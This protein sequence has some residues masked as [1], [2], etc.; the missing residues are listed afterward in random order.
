M[1]LNQFFK[2]QNISIPSNQEQQIQNYQ[3]IQRQQ[4]QQSQVVQQQTPVDQQ[5]HFTTGI[6]DNTPINTMNVGDCVSEYLAI[7]GHL[8]TLRA[9][10]RKWNKRSKEIQTRM[11]S[12]LKSA[13]K[14]KIDINK[15]ITLSYEV[16]TQQVPLTK[17]NIRSTLSQHFDDSNLIE[18]IYKVLTEKRETYQSEKLKKKKYKE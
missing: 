16:K 18:K 13:N 5:S 12:L 1:A 9:E 6:N 10:T 17:K 4:S 7:E 14:N 3:M 11:C 2:N 8:K 15:Q